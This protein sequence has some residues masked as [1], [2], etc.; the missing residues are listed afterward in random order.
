[1]TLAGFAALLVWLAL[2][3]LLGH[4][5]DLVLSRIFRSSRALRLFVGVGVIV[6]ELSHWG[7][8]VLTRTRV[9]EVALF[10]ESGGHVRHERRGPVVMAFIGTAPI[11]GSALFMMFLVWLFSQGGVRFSA[12]GVDLEDP[13]AS[14]G[15]LLWSAGSTLWLNFSSPGPGTVLFLVFLYL[16][17]S[18]VACIAPSRPDF[19]HALAGTVM[20]ALACVL[21]M[22]LQPLAFLGAGPTPVL[23]FIGGRLAGAIGIGLFLSVIPLAIGIPLALARSR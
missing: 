15:R 1:M 20:V 22:I 17:W 3:V 10:E 9:Y 12:S 21:A 5:N 7:A 6:H 16:V 14:L 11:L 18:V 23:D 19:R 2:L 13:V 8:C 4:L